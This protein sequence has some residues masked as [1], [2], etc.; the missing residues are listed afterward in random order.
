MQSTLVLVAAVAALC[1]SAACA[2]DKAVPYFG[3]NHDF[4]WTADDDIPGLIQAMS[5][6]NVQIVRVPVRWTVVEPEKGKWEFSKVDRV[7]SDITAAGIEVLAVLMS[8]PAWASGVDPKNEEGFW[9]C[10]PPKCIGDYEGFV[11]RCVSRYKDKVRFW[12]VWNEENGAD[13]Y[14]PAPDSGEYVWLLRSAY[15]TVKKTD[16]RA[17]VLLGGLQ[18]N[19]IIPNPWLTIKTPNFLQKIYHA[20]GKRYFDVVNIHPYVLAGAAEGPAY[21]AK[22]VRDTI[23]VMRRNGDGAKPLWITETGIAANAAVTEEAQ[24][25]HL[26]GIYR[27][28]MQIPQVKSVHWFTLRDY[29]SSICGGEDS[30]GMITVDGRRKPSFEVYRECA[31]RGRAER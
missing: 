11:H 5:D 3:V 28:L 15:R 17:T 9:D 4:V 22:L 18:A 6:A 8:V 2:A 16:P 31:S 25:T 7:I 1:C 26:Q 30:M 19:G 23:E 12:E 21:C 24:A 29:P 27:E 14:R 10:Y 13:F 20:G